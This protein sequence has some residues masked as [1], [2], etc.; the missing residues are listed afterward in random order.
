M[1]TQTPPSVPDLIADF[2]NQL[3][4]GLETC[5]T[6]L[7]HNLHA[8][9]TSMTTRRWLRMIV[10]VCGYIMIR[11]YIDRF[12]RWTYDRQ[13]RKEKERKQAQMEAFGAAGKKAKVSPNSLREAGKVLGEVEDTDDDEVDSDSHN[14][15]SKG[16]ATGVPEWGKN[17]RKRQ[18]KYLKNLEREAER[19]AEQLTDQQILELLDWSESEDEKEK[20]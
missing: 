2:F 9:L 10:I 17:A 1:A 12:F 15:G 3:F 7:S 13:Q 14:N 5:F 6:R 11:P 18:K 4:A 19:R 20:K 8:S 16:K